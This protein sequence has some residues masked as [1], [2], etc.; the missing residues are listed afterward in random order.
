MLKYAGYDIVFQ[1]IPDGVTLAISLTNCPNRC[2]GCHS[3]QLRDD[4]GEPLTEEVLEALLEK[5]RG[6]VTCVCLMGGD[7]DPAG[8]KRI[9]RFLHTQ[10]TTPVKAGW[11]SGR[12]ELPE[13]FSTEGIEYLKLGPYIEKL[14][15]LRAPTTNQRLYKVDPGGSLRD[16]T[17]RFRRQ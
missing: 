4:T 1:E 13:G 15:G 6:A 5:Y 14:G 2:P 12:S 16:I 17:H 8:I 10:R 9:A 7:G 3:P 11:Y